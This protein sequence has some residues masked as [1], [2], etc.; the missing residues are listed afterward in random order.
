ML[1]NMTLGTRRAILFG[2]AMT[3]MGMAIKGAIS[4]IVS[5]NTAFMIVLSLIPMIISK[6]RKLA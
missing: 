1:H 2:N 5:W 6:I 3:S 4:A